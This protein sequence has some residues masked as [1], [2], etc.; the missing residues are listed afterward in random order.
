MK[1]IFLF[2]N[3]KIKHFSHIQIIT[4]SVFFFSLKGRV[5]DITAEI[6]SIICFGFSKFSA[7]I[8][9]F[10]KKKKISFMNHVR[11]TGP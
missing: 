6:V 4:V 1:F 7:D 10:Q 11:D 9:F 8:F 2:S 3:P 5:D